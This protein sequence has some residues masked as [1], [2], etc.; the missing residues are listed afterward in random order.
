MLT[1]QVTIKGQN[2]LRSTKS[3]PKNIKEK[4]VKKPKYRIQQQRFSLT[5]YFPVSRWSLGFSCGRKCELPS[6]GSLSFSLPFSA[7]SYPCRQAAFSVSSPPPLS[8]FLHPWD[9]GQRPTSPYHALPWHLKPLGRGTP[10]F[11]CLCV[12][13]YTINGPVP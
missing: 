9:L 5:A 2:S 4:D 6:S 3:R 12:S 13:S 8:W 10:I 1:S 7:E 11:P